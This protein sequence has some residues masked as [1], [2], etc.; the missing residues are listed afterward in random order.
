MSEY[1]DI[2]ITEA[3]EQ[4]DIAEQAI[5]N[6]ETNSSL[7]F[8]EEA[9]RS[10][11]TFKGASHMFEF[12]NLGEFAHLVETILDGIRNGISTGGEELTSKLFT[13]IDHLRA[14]MKDPDLQQE[15]NKSKHQVYTK[16]IQAISQNFDNELAQLEKVKE[17]T[18]LEDQENTD[19]SDFSTYYLIIKPKIEL[20]IGSN[21]PIFGIL[22]DIK[23]MGQAKI[24]PHLLKEENQQEK[25]FK[26]WDIY[27]ACKA[28]GDDLEALFMFVDDE[29]E[30]SIHKVANFNLFS[31]EGFRTELEDKGYYDKLDDLYSYVDSLKPEAETSTVSEEES[32]SISDNKNSSL[33]KLSSIRVDSTKID[34]LMDLVSELVTNQASLTLYNKQNY[35]PHLKGIAE[36][37]S[38]HLGQLRELA[39]QM[40]L[41]SIESMIGRMKRLVRD[42][43]TK[44]GKE[45]EFEVLGENTEIDKSFIEALSDPI[46]HILRNAIDHGIESAEEREAASK[47]K[48]GK[49]S[50]HAYY[51]GAYVHIEIKDDGKGLDKEA[52]FKKA[53]SKKLIEPDA[54][55]SPKQ[56]YNLIFTPGFSTAS[57]VTDVS[58]RGVGMDVVYKNI[59]SLNGNVELDSQPGQGSCITIKV[60]LTLSIADGLLLKV[61]EH[62]FIIPLQLIHK[63]YIVAS[64]ELENNFSQTL[65]LDGQKTPFVSLR[66]ELLIHDKPIPEQCNVIS[67]MSDGKY[68]GIV[69]D[70]IVDE[71]QA[72]IKPKGEHY[73]HQEFLSGASI[74]GDGTVALV[75]DVN[76]L[77]AQKKETV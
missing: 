53:V 28:S 13:Y 32:E 61:A 18:M 76:K 46:M 62:F 65:I 59:L 17:E 35:D 50:L 1:N 57:K 6:F 2:F 27:I 74:L 71:F 5:L 73:R 37:M 69:V 60:P 19:D 14:M 40:S 12:T 75:L 72:V 24:T 34:Q 55:L 38:S 48:K 63:C 3:S 54:V 45:I 66:D 70:E 29:I 23:E 10:L 25:T 7:E 49:V 47:P 8:I 36:K 4:L 68:V 11:H 43:S 22:D 16:E 58:G 42:S 31:Q 21:H 30:L 67:V 41:V 51:S 44:L 56:L 9:F 39:F 52:I 26:H 64:N 15:S 77:I 33:T 20:N